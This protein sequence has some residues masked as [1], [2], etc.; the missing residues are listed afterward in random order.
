MISEPEVLDTISKSADELNFSQSNILILHADNQPVPGGFQSWKSLLDH[1]EEDWVRFD[2][3]ETSKN[4][5][6]MLLFSSGTTGLP[7][8]AMLSHYNFVAEHS[9][10]WDHRPPPYEVGLH[11]VSRS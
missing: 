2:D 11:V 1:G 9:L 6:A 8:A 3:I 10:V 7:K 5:A 4:T